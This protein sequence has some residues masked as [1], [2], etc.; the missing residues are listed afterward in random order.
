MFLIDFQN[1]N[2]KIVI[3]SL[4]YWSVYWA[5]WPFAVWTF[6]GQSVSLRP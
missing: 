5:G 3:S 1:F 2:K 4:N 6:N